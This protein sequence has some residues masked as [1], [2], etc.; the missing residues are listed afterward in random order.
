MVKHLM[1]RGLAPTRRPSRDRDNRR[2]SCRLCIEPLED[3]LLLSDDMVLRWND[4]LLVA[5]RAAGQ[6]PT[7][8]TRFAAIVQ[9]AVYDAVNSID[10]T[11]TPY[12]AAI[13]AP[14]GADQG[15]AAA[16]AAHDAMLGL[17][18]AQAT[19][20]DLELKA[21]L[22]GIADGDAKTAGIMV[23]QTAAQNILAARADDGS[24]KMVSYTPGTNPGDW[25]PTPPAYAAPLQPQWPQVTP[26]CL[27]SASQ[28]R[29]SP[30]PALTSPE[31]KSAFNQVRALGSFDRTSRPAD[32]T[33]AAMFW[34]AIATP[35]STPPGLWNK[36]AQVAAVS[37]SNTLV[38][39]ARL[40][41][42]L[43]L[44][45]AD[46][47]IACWDAKYTYNF[48]RPVTAIRAADTTGNPD[49]VA[50]PNWTPLM[51]T[52][53]HPSY[54]SAHATELGGAAA[55]LT[56]FFGTDAIPFSISW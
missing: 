41:A 13:P 22:Q 21:S 35:T 15:A 23:G 1:T 46:E 32:E 19:T 6:S 52:P 25:Q 24:N 54:P 11:Y 30:P 20:L 33:E 10:G 56:S 47:A 42:L 12:L 31:N 27:Q 39:N 34:Q 8:S 38:Q 3:S 2:A 5:L 49:T 26:F 55:A 45:L 9:A 4:S 53:A 48:W 17:F 51:A 14:A 36:I 18:P 29:P 40:F 44:T 43:D 37:Q 28:F 7:P 16:Q 50:D